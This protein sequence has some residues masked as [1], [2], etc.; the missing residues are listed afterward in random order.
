MERMRE[1]TCDM[2]ESV[3]WSLNES[4]A[5][6]VRFD[7]SFWLLCQNVSPLQI[8]K[9]PTSCLQHLKFLHS[10]QLRVSKTMDPDADAAA[11]LHAALCIIKWKQ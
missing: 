9:Q 6:Y 2:R 7:R 5:E 4:H 1:I 10:H 3:R 11:P 8:C